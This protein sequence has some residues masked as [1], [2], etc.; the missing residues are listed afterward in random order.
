V[1]TFPSPGANYCCCVLPYVR[2]LDLFWARVAL[3]DATASRAV[4]A[5]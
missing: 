2:F 4:L 3:G 1:H 5:S